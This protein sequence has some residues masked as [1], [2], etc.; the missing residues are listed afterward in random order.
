MGRYIKAVER[1]V[2]DLRREMSI[3]AT[4][5]FFGL[6]WRA[7]KDIEKRHLKTKFKRIRLRDVTIIGIDE[8]YVGKKSIKRSFEI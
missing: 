8:I 2:I 5:E 3:K 4:A 6:D 7:V 1:S